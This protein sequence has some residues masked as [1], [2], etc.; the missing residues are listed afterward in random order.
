MS[1]IGRFHSNNKLSLVDGVN[2]R[3]K[4]PAQNSR[5]GKLV[6]LQKIMNPSLLA[7]QLNILILIPVQ[8]SLSTLAAHTRFPLRQETELKSKQ[9]FV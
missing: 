9:N 5:L 6:G 4:K 7:F 3:N 8:L 2:L 1:L